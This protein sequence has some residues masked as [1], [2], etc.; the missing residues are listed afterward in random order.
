MRV[1]LLAFLL[2]LPSC[3]VPMDDVQNDTSDAGTQTIS[4]A[5]VIGTGGGVIGIGGEIPNTNQ[6]VADARQCLSW[7]EAT[8][9]WCWLCWVACRQRCNNEFSACT[10]SPY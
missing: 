2:V 3:D 1:L 10:L 8:V 9:N 4:Q 7:C 6:C 5:Q